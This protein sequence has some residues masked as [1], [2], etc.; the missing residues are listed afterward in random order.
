MNSNYVTIFK[1]VEPGGLGDDMTEEEMRVYEEEQRKID[2]YEKEKEMEQRPTRRQMK[3]R[4]PMWD[5]FSEVLVGGLL[6][7]GKCKYC[8][9][10]IKAVPGVNGTSALKS[11]FATCKFNPH[12]DKN[13]N[14]GTL[15]VIQGE[16]PSVHKFDP[17]ALRKAIAKMII[18]DELPFAFSEKTGFRE[19][20]SIACPRFNMPSRRTCTRDVV[21]VYFEERAKLKLFFKQSCQRVCLTTDGWTSQTQD[22]YMTVTAHFIDPE[23]NLH[24][25]IISFFLVKGHKGDDIGKAIEQCLMEWGIN[26]VMT[27]TVDNASANDGGVG[28]IR[29]KIIKTG[30]SIAEGKYF[31]MRCAAHIINLIVTDGLKELDESVKRVRAAVRYIRHGPSRITRFKELAQLEKVDSEAFLSLDVCTRWNSTY[32][33]LK[34]AI[35]FEK[36]FARYEEED[37]LYT[38]DLTS[39]KAPG[40]PVDSDWENATKM[41][42]FLGQFYHLTLSVSATLHVTVNQFVMDIAK[43]NVVLEEWADS[44][45]ILRKTMAKKMQD[46]YDK[47]WGRWH[48]EVEN[49]RGKGKGKKKEEENVNM[50]VFA[51]TVLDPRFKLSNFTKLAIEE[52]YGELNGGKAWEAVKTFMHALFEEYKA[53]YAPSDASKHVRAP[54]SEPT[55]KR[56]GRKLVSRIN[57]M[58]RVGANAEASMSKSEFEKYLH[59]ENEVNRDD[60]NILKWWKDNAARFPILARMARDVLAVPVSTVV[61]ETAFSTSGRILN[62]FRTSLTPFMV[63]ALVCAQDWLRG[64]I[65]INIE[66]DEEELLRL[67]K[68]NIL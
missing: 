1:M 28:Y 11:H 13:K 55:Q 58:F 21:K 42:E 65:T 29:K 2:E 23:W 34:T 3:K 8:N 49:E 5:H 17:E 47:Y 44:D 6:K 41:A 30:N 18:V 66:E 53:K 32:L 43:V 46:K 10:D 52:M 40:I 27:I 57:K 25:K 31:H 15:Q 48:E 20:M 12:N 36:V 63:Q 19:V 14:Q 33:M 59:E 64:S 26:K 37:P 54:Q 16:S 68:G 60:F 50:F 67:E 56:E 22:C 7:F 24:K 62:E 38:L 4:S 61:S 9:R 51:A 39:E 45:D 35:N